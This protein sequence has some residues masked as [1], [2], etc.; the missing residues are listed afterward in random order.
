MRT[1]GFNWSQGQV[2]NFSLSKKLSCG[3]DRIAWFISVQWKW[4]WMTPYMQ[5]QQ[6]LKI[7]S[8]VFY[9]IHFKNKAK[10]AI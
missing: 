4:P 1:L 8:G 3:F 6:M 10:Q 9:F 2:Q 5:I 7:T